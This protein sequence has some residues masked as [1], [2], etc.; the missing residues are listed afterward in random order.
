MQRIEIKNFGPIK[1]CNLDI[2]SFMVFI[3]PQATGKS[4]ISKLIYF[5]KAI[6][7]Y[8]FENFRIIYTTEQF[9]VLYSA[10]KKD[11]LKRFEN[12]FGFIKNITSFSL[13]Y[14]YENEDIYIQIKKQD[15][16]SQIDI[17]FNFI[18]ISRIEEIFINLKTLIDSKWDSELKKA[19]SVEQ[20]LALA[21]TNI[22]INDIFW[23]TERLFYIPAGRSLL[24][25]MSVYDSS[26]FDYLMNNFVKIISN[27]KNSFSKSMEE[28]IRDKIN[29]EGNLY[30]SGK[31]KKAKINID[32]ILKA[33]YM[34]ENGFERIYYNEN[35]SLDIRFASSG[36][37]ESLWILL[38]IFAII[39]DDMHTFTVFEEPE[40]HLFPESQKLLIELIA[41]LQYQGSNKVIITTHSPYT[42]TALNNL[43][44]AYNKAIENKKIQN[45]I[46]KIVD[47]DFWINSGD[48]NAYY[49]DEGKIE[50]IFDS[51]LK[52]I[53]AEAIDNVSRILNDEYDR[54]DDLP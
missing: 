3:G 8:I 42:L 26:S 21:N 40:A 48:F 53:K 19:L 24:S 25:I 9:S 39:R 10:L 16:N 2:N 11:I 17:V 36:Q 7:D 4:T 22:E 30:Y 15:I 32:R 50:S 13:L 44:F 34:Y 31:I 29:Q 14:F 27:L 52:L 5:F 20:Q 37:Q 49:V 6:P 38:L 51:D 18:V 28:L 47:R 54:I 43:L 23:I 33:R 12:I 45:S 46:E 1:E 35:E 41:L